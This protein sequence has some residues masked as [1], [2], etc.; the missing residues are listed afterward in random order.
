MPT[1]TTSRLRAELKQNRPFPSPQQEAAVALFR[2]VDEL[3]R[4]YDL[5][6][7][8]FGITAQQYNVLRI[9]RGVHPDPLPTLEIG[10]RLIERVPG[11]TRLLDRLEAKGLVRRARCTT[12]RRMV[13]C[14]ISDEGLALLA[15]MDDPIDQAG[16]E[17][18]A[19]LTGAETETLI[20]LLERIREG[21]G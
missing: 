5:L 18:M 8:P 9:L 21:T 4:R 14:W 13:H 12:D 2:T 16:R 19:N 3:R 1:S 11:I 7:D 6:I 20:G 15:R 17:S 10:E